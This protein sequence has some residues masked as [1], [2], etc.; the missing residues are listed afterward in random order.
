M[1]YRI[2]GRED[3]YYRRLN[4]MYRK[5]K[6]E[7]GGGEFVDGKWKPTYKRMDFVDVVMRLGLDQMERKS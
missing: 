2:D 3:K 1:S 4:A 6:H 7:A 5:R